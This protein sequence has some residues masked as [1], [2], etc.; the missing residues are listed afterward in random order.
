MSCQCWVGSTV[1]GESV[2]VGEEGPWPPCEIPSLLQVCPHLCP[3]SFLRKPRLESRGHWSAVTQQVRGRPRLEFRQPVPQLWS[4]LEGIQ[5]ER[6][7]TS[8]SS[9]FG[10]APPKLSFPSVPGADGAA[11]AGRAEPG[12]F[13]ARLPAWPGPGP[14]EADPGGEA[15]GA[16]AA[17]G[18]VCPASPHCC[19]GSPQTLP[20]CSCP[21]HRGRPG[22]TSSAPEPAPLGLPPSAPTEGLPRVPPWPSPSAEP[23][24]LAARAPPPVG[25]RVW[26]PQWGPRHT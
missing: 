2:E 7:R 17:P 21:A 6:E 16:A 10:C 25:S 15:A 20:C 26:S 14:P 11:A 1:L 3:A 13:P 19:C 22:A 24:A 8:Q 23:S 18:A 9:V 12:G 4:P 5:G